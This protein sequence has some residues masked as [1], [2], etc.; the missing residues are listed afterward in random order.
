MHGS[1]LLSNDHVGVSALSERAEALQQLGFAADLLSAEECMA[2]E[3]LVHIGSA[4]AGLRVTSDF[5]IDA[6]TACMWLLARCHELGRHKSRFRIMFGTSINGTCMV[7]L[8]DKKG[9]LD[10]QTHKH[11]ERMQG[12]ARVPRTRG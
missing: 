8:Q 1:L 4:G 5:H 7:G 11:S 2:A 10:T 6:A 9:R 3:R 12:F